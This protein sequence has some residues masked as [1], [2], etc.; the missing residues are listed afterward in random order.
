[1]K[2]KIMHS[3]TNWNIRLTKRASVA[4]KKQSEKTRQEGV[5]QPQRNQMTFEQNFTAAQRKRKSYSE[6]RRARKKIDVCLKG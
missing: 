3:K 1:M 5:Y 2:T 6:K 4:Y